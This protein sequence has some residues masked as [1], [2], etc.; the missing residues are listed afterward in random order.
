[1]LFKQKNTEPTDNLDFNYEPRSVS[2]AKESIE[3]MNIMQAMY[4]DYIVTKTGYLAGIIEISGINLELLNNFEQA[5]VFDTYNSF[6]MSTLGDNI[7]EQQQYLDMTIPVDFNEYLLS[8]KKRYLDEINKEKPN[9]A[10]ANLIAS[11]IDDLTQ[12]QQNQDMSTKKHLLVVRERI[13]NKT[14]TALDKTV[15]DLNET[16]QQYISRLEDSFDNYELQAK[17]LSGKEIS[18]VLKNLINFTGH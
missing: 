15:Q 3:E 5:D 16:I 6:L 17:K 8:Y 18:K 1:L 13:N 4:K 7:D 11:Y 10:R 12:K 14:L 9:Y 2:K